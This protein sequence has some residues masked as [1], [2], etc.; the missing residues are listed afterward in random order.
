MRFP[1]NLRP[2]G[3]IG[4][5]APSFGCATEPY[6]SG[7]QNALKTFEKMGYQTIL[8]PNCTEAKGVG[9]SNAPELCGKEVISASDTRDRTT[10][11]TLAILRTALFLMPADGAVL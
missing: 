5:L 2:G 4:F 1:M 8:G 3:T 11:S 7:F 6:Y 9:I 10:F